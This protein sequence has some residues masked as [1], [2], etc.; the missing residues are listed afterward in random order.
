MRSPPT[1][2][3]TNT[4]T[5][6][7]QQNRADSCEQALITET[8]NLLEKWKH[9]DPYR[10]PTAPGGALLYPSRIY[11]RHGRGNGNANNSLQAQS[12]SATC[13]A[14]S[15]I[16]SAPLLYMTNGALLIGCSSTEMDEPVSGWDWGIR[17]RAFV[18]L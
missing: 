9:P 17:G 15:W 5:T 14:R 1:P 2:H 11:I 16:V 10:P 6:T 8:E 4:S 12:T 18:A 7:I 3:T 13:L